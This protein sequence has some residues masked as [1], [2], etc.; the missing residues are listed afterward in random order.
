MN[1]FFELE[2][3]IS[4]FFSDIFKFFI[5]IAIWFNLFWL[6]QKTF[7]QDLLNYKM[8]KEIEFQGN[9]IRKF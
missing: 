3:E 6:I 4:Y 9:I 7:S 8:M 1:N 5:C 2:I